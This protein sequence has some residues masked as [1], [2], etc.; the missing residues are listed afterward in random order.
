MASAFPPLSD[1]HPLKRGRAED[2]ASF[3]ARPKDTYPRFHVIHKE[4]SD[5]SARGISP[6][7]VAKLLTE[8][9][10]PGYKI[11]RMASG[12]LLLEVR[13][14]HQYKKLTS[15]HTLGDIPVSVNT[16]QVH[17]DHSA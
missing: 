5:K 8:N 1:R 3:L 10:G 14:Q 16:T 12:D 17:G 9:L 4:I 6:F 13:D 15:L 11:T 2:L 7:I